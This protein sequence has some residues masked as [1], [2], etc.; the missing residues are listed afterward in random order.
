VWLAAAG[1]VAADGVTPYVVIQGVEMGRPSRLE[2]VVRCEGGA[3][4]ESSVT[5]RSVPIARGQIRKP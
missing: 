5:G 2:C 1:H 3:A 4:V